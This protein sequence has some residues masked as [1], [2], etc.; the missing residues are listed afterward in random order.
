MNDSLNPVMMFSQILTMCAE[1][2]R[3]LKQQYYHTWFFKLLN[4]IAAFVLHVLTMRT[5]IL[6]QDKINKL[7]F[8]GEPNRQSVKV[9][10]L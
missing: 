3:Q 10:A 8:T 4:H 9:P 7:C 5:A 2:L 6:Y 1:S